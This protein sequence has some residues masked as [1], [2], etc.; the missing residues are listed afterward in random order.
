MATLPRG[1]LPAIN[2]A[3]KSATEIRA[4]IITATEAIIGRSLADGDPLRLFLESIATIIINQR[5][6]IDFAAKQN[7]LSYVTDE[8][9]DYLAELVGVTRLAAKPA[10]TTIRFTLS[11]AQASVYTVPAGTLL[12]AG[13]LE[14]TTTEAL[15]IPIGNTTGDV[16][17]QCTTAGII[18]NNLLP[19]QIKTLVNP[20]PFVQSA[21][22]ITTSSGGAEIEG[23]E[24]MVERIRLAPSSFS[25]A[26]PKDAYVFWALTANQS[27]IDVSVSTPTPGVVDVRPLLEGGSLP[28]TEVLDQ[29]EAV[30]S[31]DD[32]RPITDNVL[33][34]SPDAV[35]YDVTVDYW[36][37]TSDAASSATIQSAVQAAIDAYILW[38]K[39]KIG[40]DIIPDELIRRMIEAGAK[41]VT[42][43]SPSYTVLSDTDVAQDG[44]VTVTYQGL[45]NG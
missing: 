29:V 38:Q 14:F 32:I 37:R 25:V 19:G 33:V 1:N 6:I 21:A 39:T 36:I 11:T 40:R 7:L 2:F 42:V 3:E 12:N 43:T 24:S 15:E 27:I 30:L 23:V 22:N 34:Q 16:L 8:Y 41:R 4:S 13:T 20:L 18:G 31:A 10:V 45:E 26:G 17:A 35:P 9:V 5:S 44:T 28:S